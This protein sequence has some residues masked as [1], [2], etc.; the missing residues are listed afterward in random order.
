[1]PGRPAQSVVGFRDIHCDSKLVVY[2]EQ[3]WSTHACTAGILDPVVLVPLTALNGCI[4]A[5][6]YF[7]TEPTISQILVNGHAMRTPP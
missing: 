4:G 6:V 3:L 5:F 2:M 7:P 1:M